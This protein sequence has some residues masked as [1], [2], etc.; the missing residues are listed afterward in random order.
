MQR[1]KQASPG[2]CH[3][4]FALPANRLAVPF[5][6]VVVA[7]SRAW[8]CPSAAAVADKTK[9]AADKQAVDRVLAQVKQAASTA[10]AA[11]RLPEPVVKQR[12]GAQQA[13]AAPSET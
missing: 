12:V 3:A 9:Q 8:C 13:A 11:L 4:P 7:D 6:P 2:W 1:R 5:W 10:K